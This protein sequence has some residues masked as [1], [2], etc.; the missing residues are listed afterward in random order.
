MTCRHNR[1]ITLIATEVGLRVEKIVQNKH[2][3]VHV[4][5]PDGRRGILGCSVSPGDRLGFAQ[6]FRRQCRRFLEGR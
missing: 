1:E 5:A 2:N 6:Q 3:K 4:T